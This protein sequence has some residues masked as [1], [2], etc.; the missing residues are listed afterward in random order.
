VE[1]ALEREDR[2]AS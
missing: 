2:P 1:N